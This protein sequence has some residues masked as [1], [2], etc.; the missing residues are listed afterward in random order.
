MKKIFMKILIM[1]VIL[2]LILG[3]MFFKIKKEKDITDNIEKQEFDISRSDA[4]EN[5]NETNTEIAPEENKTEETESKMNETENISIEQQTN[6]EKINITGTNKK[7]ENNVETQSIAKNENKKAEIAKSEVKTE[8]K[9]SKT[10]TKQEEKTETVTTN[11]TNK[12]NTE[13]KIP[14]QK[15]EETK[16]ENTSYYKR[17]DQMI[18]KIRNAIIRNESEDMKEYGYEIIVDSSIKEKT[19]QFT[20]TEN[21]VKNSIV[22]RFGTIRIYAEDYYVNNQLIMTECYIF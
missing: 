3:I 22:N 20:F 16:A 2:I 8:T 17:N 19:N 15:K 9:N 13:E 10:D 14:E 18:E 1:V 5:I 12:T 11:N 4:T 7:K 21:R 6:S